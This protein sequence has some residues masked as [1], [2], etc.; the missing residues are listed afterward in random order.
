VRRIFLD[1]ETFYS[2]TYTLRTVTPLQYILDKR[3]EML[4][5]GV[6]EDNAPP[7]F[8]PQE[9]VI[10]YLEN[11]TEP[12][13]AIS[14]N[15][16]FDMTILAWRYGIH[17]PLMVDTM[18]MSRALI[19]H[20][21]KQSRVSLEKVLEYFGLEAKLTTIKD[22]EG[23]NFQMLTSNRD[24]L[25]MFVTY[26]LRDV[27]GCREIYNLLIDNFPASELRVMDR[28]IRMTTMPQ[29]L[30]DELNLRIYYGD[31][32]RAKRKLLDVLGYDRAKYMSNDQFADLLKER[33]VDPPM[34]MSAR[35]HKMTYAFARTDEDFLKLQEH[36][37]EEVQA[38][39]AARLGLKSTIEETRTERFIHMAELTASSY[40]TTWMPVPLKYS[41]A[42]THRLSGDWKLNMQNL[43]TRKT[44]VLRSAIRAPH[45]C[46]ILDVDASQIEARLVAWLAG[47]QNL[48]EQFSDPLNDVYAWFG[49]QIYGYPITKKTHPIERFNSKTIVLGLGFG[50]SAAKLLVKLTFDALEAGI[51][52]VYTIEQC[53]A[54]VD[55]YRTL[56]PWIPYLWKRCGWIL[57]AMMDPTWPKQD[58][59]GPCVTEG[60][61]ILLPSGLRLYYNDLQTVEGNT[62]YLYGSMRRYIYGAKL[63]EN[64]V[65]ALDWIHVIEANMRIEDRCARQGLDIRLA[66]QVHDA[67]A[68]VVPLDCLQLVKEIAL[69]EMCRS[70]KWAPD[71]P[72]AAEAKYGQSYG[73]LEKC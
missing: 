45:G 70:P 12:Y 55:A 2:K 33:G 27:R 71:I 69:E 36:P 15:A 8:L 47:Q 6:A 42:H 43:S 23:V 52:T 61:T 32:M 9:K 24:L 28:V 21:T 35:T 11:I 30:L 18:S 41:G 40:G 64:I 29:L 49:S 20:V 53:Q 37:D 22:M 65:Q 50:M 26:T 57:E 25:M 39:V 46:V 16:L 1:F 68:Y 51:N 3:F 67:N 31:I 73:G 63:T 62:T 48:L 72:L 19:G 66:L 60:Q 59:I 7:F 17:P 34:K 56:F 58:P 38:L 13:A 44:N 5:C 4:G 14:H 10:S 54:W